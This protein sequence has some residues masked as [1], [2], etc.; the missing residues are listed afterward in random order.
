MKMYKQNPIKKSRL[1][2]NKSKEGETIE[3]R[4]ARIMHSGEKIKDSAPLI[5]EE[6]GKGVN[7]AHDVR[8]DRWAVA[9]E[10]ADKMT[11]SR[12][13]RRE[14]NKPTPSPDDEQPKDQDDPGPKKTDG[15]K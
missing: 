6:R 11:A 1:T 12:I 2:I 9:L 3:Q 13:A 14:Q 7:P 5:Y 8:T 15:S 4:I 10:A